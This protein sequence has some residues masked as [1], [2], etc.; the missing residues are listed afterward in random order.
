MRT[1][2]DLDRA[3]PAPAP[4]LKTHRRRPRRTDI[5]SEAMRADPA[6]RM[7]LAPD[8]LDSL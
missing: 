5:V 7:Q 2:E 8:E 1:P 6:L 3:E 4:P